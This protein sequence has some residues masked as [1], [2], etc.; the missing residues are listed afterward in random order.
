MIVKG[1]N[2]QYQKKH[3]L[4]DVIRLI[5]AL[6][7]ESNDFKTE[8]DIWFPLIAA[9]LA[10]ITL[11]LTSFSTN[12]YAAKNNLP[13]TNKNKPAARVRQPK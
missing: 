7:L 12:Y 2:R 1:R 5:N 6:G 8:K 3:R 10:S 4:G 13:D 9:I 11:I